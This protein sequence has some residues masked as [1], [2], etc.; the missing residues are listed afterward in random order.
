MACVG[1]GVEDFI[2]DFHARDVDAVGREQFIVWREVNCGNGKP[3]ADA[4]V[5]DG[6]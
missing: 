1:D 2:A 3:G 4:T 6:R 5:A